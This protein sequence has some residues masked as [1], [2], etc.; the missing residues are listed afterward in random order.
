MRTED[1]QGKQVQNRG[2]SRGTAPADSA[3]NAQ[4]LLE[5]F[6]LPPSEAKTLV[7][8][9]R[10]GSATA[11]QLAGVTGIDRTNLYRVLENLQR[12]Q[13][14]RRS[15]ERAAL[16]VAA[17]R[18]EVMGLLR[19]REQERSRVA[20]E[21]L[22]H[23]DGALQAIPEPEQEARA[24]I[25]VVEEAA[26]SLRYDEAVTST[27][28]EV[29]VFNRGPYVGDLRVDPSV[30]AAITGGA[31]AR[32]LWQAHEVY[33][34]ESAEAY[35]CALAYSEVGADTRVVDELPISMAVIDR[36]VALLRLP[37]EGSRD[38]PYVASLVV[39]NA[40]FGRAMAALFQ[41]FWAQG[42]P[43]EASGTRGAKEPTAKLAKGG[44]R[45]RGAP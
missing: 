37:G 34:A 43:L 44:R 16:W 26:L 23:L 24:A 39:T 8:I 30:E 19:Q 31:S 7:A 20:A 25:E 6:S 15:P 5:Q 12:R 1:Q 28:T 2:R 38:L 18:K 35:A 13:L 40:A 42:I 22:E 11:I 32:A 21:A 9:M 33:G 27:T 36:A 14:V 29:L 10:L 41:H 17:G 45:A 4:Q 3:E